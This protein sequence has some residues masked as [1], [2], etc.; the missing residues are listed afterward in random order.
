MQTLEVLWQR[1]GRRINQLQD[2]ERYDFLHAFLNRVLVTYDSKAKEHQLHLEL[3]V[4]V[5]EEILPQSLR[6]LLTAESP[7]TTS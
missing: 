1:I 3:A 7:P 4:E 6:F 5:E 2:R